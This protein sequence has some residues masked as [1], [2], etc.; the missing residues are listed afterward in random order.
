MCGGGGRIT[1]YIRCNTDVQ[2]EYPPFSGLK[3]YEWPYFF[4]VWYI[5]GPLFRGLSISIA[6]KLLC[7]LE[8]I[9]ISKHLGPSDLD[10][11]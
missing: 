7:F 5:N 1:P 4:R 9:F 6:L 2:P 8:I 10:S 3:V 11:G